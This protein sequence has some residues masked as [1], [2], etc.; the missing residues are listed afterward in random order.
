MLELNADN[1][2]L[3]VYL[4]SS[5]P[6]KFQTCPLLNYTLDDF[7]KHGDQ[8]IHKETGYIFERDNYVIYD[9]V[10]YLCVSTLPDVD[11]VL[12]YLNLVG[13]ILSDIFLV[14]SIITY[15]VLAELRTVPGLLIMNLCISLLI[16]QLLFLSSI[17]SDGLGTNCLTIAILLHFSWLCTFFWTNSIAINTYKTFSNI[18]ASRPS[19]KSVYYTVVIV[20]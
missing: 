12:F 8:M 3:W 9:G 5:I 2:E 13:F 17:I 1:H 18:L 16:A 15:A 11:Q 19:K 10:I 4:C 6:E 14:Y 20:M 7:I